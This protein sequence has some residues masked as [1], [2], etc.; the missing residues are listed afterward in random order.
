MMFWMAVYGARDDMDLHVEAR[1]R[2]AV[3]LLDAV[4]VVDDELLGQDMKDLL[5]P[6]DVD[7]PGGVNGPRHVGGADLPV[8]DGGHALRL[9]PLDVVS[10]DPH[11]DR[12][13]LHAGHELRFLH[14]FLDGLHGAVDVHHHALFQAVGR[15]DADP[16]DVHLAVVLRFAD[17]GADLGRTQVKT[18]DD[19]VRFLCHDAPPCNGNRLKL[20]R[21]EVE[22]D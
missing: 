6:G 15:A 10:G 9:E 19:I 16:D 21:W 11:I 22:E 20:G 17:D 3:G 4:L 18:Y 2:H 1:S 14:R 8:L 5:G 7:G 12:V 13:D